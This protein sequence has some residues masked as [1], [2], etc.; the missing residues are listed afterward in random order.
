MNG[1]AGFD[2]PHC[3][4]EHASFRDVVACI[5][6]DRLSR[7]EVDAAMDR[8]VLRLDGATHEEAM[9]AHPPPP[10]AAA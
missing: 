2:C 6:Q 7:E 1:D 5:Y 4:A 9:E 3:G 8:V 10:G